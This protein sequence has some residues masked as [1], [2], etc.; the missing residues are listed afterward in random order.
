M[1]IIT[2]ESK[3]AV[4]AERWKEQYFHDGE[5]RPGDDKR[6]AYEELMKGDHTPDRVEEILNCS[7]TMTQCGECMAYGV[8][9]VQLGEEPDYESATAYVCAP[10]LQAAIERF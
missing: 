6:L 9:V 2:R 8:P 10:C 1:K 5:W 7:W 3:A 4:A